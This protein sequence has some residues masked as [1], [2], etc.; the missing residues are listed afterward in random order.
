MRRPH[1]PGRRSSR[2]HR[3]RHLQ[4]ALGQGDRQRFDAA[5]LQAAS[6]A[7]KHD[8]K[9]A[10]GSAGVL[11]VTAFGIHQPTCTTQVV[12]HCGVDR[13]CDRVLQ[14]AAG[15]KLSSQQVAGATIHNVGAVVTA[16]DPPPAACKWIDTCEVSLLPMLGRGSIYLAQ[17]G[18]LHLH[19]LHLHFAGF[20]GGLLFAVVVGANA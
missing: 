18:S 15:M 2:F 4:Q 11:R 6:L 20:G 1:P 14:F 10:A 5:S 16:S 12:G 8:L 7:Q 13:S 3:D 17:P 9:T 19:C